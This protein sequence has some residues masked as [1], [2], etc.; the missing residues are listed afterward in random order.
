M[1]GAAVWLAIAASI[2]LGA[3]FCL[4]S[5]SRP[6]ASLEWKIYDRF[7]S[8]S[9]QPTVPRDFIVL[10]PGE[11]GKT[12]SPSADE[13]LHLFRLLDELEISSLA[14]EGQAYEGGPEEEELSSLRSELPALVDKESGSINDNIR[15]LFGAILN[16]S[17]QSKSLNRYIENLTAIVESSGQRIKE[18]VSKGWSP[19]LSEI[20]TEGERIHMP[21]DSF[22]G[23]E[24]DPDG[25]TRRLSLVIKS[26]H[27]LL[28]RVE[29]AV[30]MRRL[31]DPSLRL[32]PGRLI[33]VGA[34]AA[35][36]R[37]QD[38]GIPVDSEG[39]ALIRWP[40]PGAKIA[41]RR[42]DLSQLFQAIDEERIFISL[43][44]NLES[45]GLLVADGAALLSREQHAEQLRLGLRAGDDAALADWREARL[46]F[47]SSAQAYF[48]AK[49]EAELISALEMEK[50]RLEQSSEALAP[51]EAQKE[52]IASSYAR[53]RASIDKLSSLRASLADSLHGSNV[54]L[55][56]SWGKTQVLTSFGE[57]ASPAAAGAAF[58]ASVLS[59]RTPFRAD[60]GLALV[61]GLLL[62]ILAG[63]ARLALDARGSL[64]LGL[65]AALLGIVLALA[66]F[67]IGGCFVSPLPLALGPAT[68][69]LALLWL[70][71]GRR[72]GGRAAESK[73]MTV[74][75]F[76][77]PGLLSAIEG[78]QASEALAALAAFTARVCKAIEVEG[79]RLASSEGSTLLA[80]FEEEAGLDAPSSRGLRAAI[81]VESQGGG[82]ALGQ[83]LGAGMDVRVGLDS[84][85]C[86]I[87]RHPTLARRGRVLLGAVADLAFRLADLNSHY[88]T[89]I[90]ATGAVFETAANGFPRSLM[91][92]LVVEA[93]GRKSTLYSV[94]AKP[95]QGSEPAAT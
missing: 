36:A 47:F 26:A 46:A 19:T 64:F 38:L 59:G 41:Q 43:L 94:A 93:T 67:L 16:G 86:L 24:P 6:L 77:A 12:A 81:A 8:I 23:T 58:A 14:M 89:H 4:L 54:F 95:E 92:D 82:A 83:E 27:G 13:V 39:R 79:G 52:K 28:P 49:P 60:P 37:S 31:G 74:A 88:G 48:R 63:G 62:S 53:A 7:L 57:V 73:M 30:L 55:S 20:Q 5:A 91:G 61:L 2:S 84:G 44:G 34:R 78:R 85:N 45:G 69:S 80:F 40:R 9:A 15:V 66:I 72:L 10:D 18:A 11:T 87:A 17:I 50:G 56:T 68:A 25:V 42:L 71:S 65:G 76:K 75:A 1:P 90:L 21:K 70:G 51:L 35:G 29:L 33:L 32:E 22:F 3:V